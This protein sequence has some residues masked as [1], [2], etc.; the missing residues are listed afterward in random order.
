MAS[1]SSSG[2]S[3]G[4]TSAATGVGLE[5]AA[6]EATRNFILGLPKDGPA[7]GS[8]DAASL[9]AAEA[10]LGEI[11][12]EIMAY[13]IANAQAMEAYARSWWTRVPYFGKRWA[14]SA[15]QMESQTQ[16]SH[17]ELGGAATG[18]AAAG[19]AAGAMKEHVRLERMTAATA[20]MTSGQKQQKM[21]TWIFKQRHPGWV[22]LIQ[23]WWVP[24]VCAAGIVL[25]WTPDVWKLRTLYWCDHRYALFRQSVHKA[26]WRATMNV[27]DYEALM[28]DMEL[29]RPPSVKATNCPL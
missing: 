17:N 12:Q 5:S 2:S 27:E 18:T 29:D 3:S 26:Y 19:A 16:C 13:D 14:A 24:C 1:R 21:N 25:I 10:F 6:G 23:R 20:G 7:P 22:P 15:D 28:R 9:Q 4:G 8:S 11:Q